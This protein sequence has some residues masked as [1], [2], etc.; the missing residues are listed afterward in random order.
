VQT[1]QRLTQ[2]VI[3]HNVRFIRQLSE[4]VTVLDFGRVIASGTPEDVL[5]DPVVVEAYIGR[6]AG[7]DKEAS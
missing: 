6:R 1:E 2:V 5:S 4:H 3:E 7:L